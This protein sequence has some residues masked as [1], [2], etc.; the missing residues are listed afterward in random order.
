[1]HSINIFKPLQPALSINL[2]DIDDFI[3]KTLG[4]LEKLQRKRGRIAQLKAFSLRTQWPWVWFLALLKF[5]SDEKIVNV[6]KDVQSS[7]Q[8][9]L[10]YVDRTHLVLASGKLVLQKI[11]QAS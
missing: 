5:F 9:R 11:K 8:Q 2:N 3:G 10:N 6:A 7:G 1:M 4:N